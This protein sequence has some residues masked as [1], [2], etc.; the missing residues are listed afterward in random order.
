M[1]REI[2]CDES[3]YEGEKLVGG[4]TDVFAHASI[5]LDEVAAAQCIAETRRRI[6]SPA[7]EYKAGHLL[8]EKHRA[9]LEWLLSPDGPLVGHAHVFLVDKALFLVRTVT[10]VLLGRDDLGEPLPGG[11]DIAE[12]VY[13]DGPAGFGPG[14]G[15]FLEAANDLLR[16][17][18]PL[19]QTSP[20]DAFYERLD[21]TVLSGASN[22]LRVAVSRLRESRPA[23]TAY[24]QRLV[25]GAT[26]IP[27][28]DPLFPAI[29]RAVTYWGR[30][31]G[32]VRVV[33][34]QQ[35]TLSPA[36]I[37]QLLAAMDTTSGGLVLADSFFDPRVQVADFL[38]GVARKI[39][40]DQL[41]GHGDA[42][43]VGLLHPFVDA[44]SIWDGDAVLSPGPA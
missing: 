2:A 27:V 40:S 25:A 24:R 34:D 1:L 30:D 19:D 15:A 43:L 42:V 7:M 5:A 39:A 21:Q 12:V 41:G 28:L 3:G 37:R 33:H 14:W 29:R 17:R 11:D 23:A 22:R 4:V 8:R 44:L 6:R 35:N 32:Q 36:R 9:V 26:A 10:A 13:R 38:A 18:D 31:G 16:R 20:A